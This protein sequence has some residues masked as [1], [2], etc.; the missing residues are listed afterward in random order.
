MGA[1][2]KISKTVAGTWNLRKTGDSRNCTR[3][4]KTDVSNTMNGLRESKHGDNIYTTSQKFLN[5]NICN[6][7]FF[8]KEVSS[9]HQACIYLIQSTAKTVYYIYY[10]I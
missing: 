10:N 8:F 7:F 6:V 1:I 4:H 5:S 9:A 2:L 3:K